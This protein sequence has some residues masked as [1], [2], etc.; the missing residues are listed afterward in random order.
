MADVAKSSEPHS[1]GLTSLLEI[2]REH[3]PDTD[4]TMLQRA[5][6]LA[7][8][9]HHGQTRKSGEPYINHPT[10]VAKI[11]AEIGMDRETIV[12]A[13]L[14]DVLEDTDIDQ[15]EI[16]ALFGEDVLQMIEG[17]TKLS[18]QISPDASARQK[19][20]A[21]SSRAAESLRKLL[22]AMAKDFRV[23]VIKLAD[24]LHNMRTISSLPPEKQTRIAN[25]T[26]DIYAPI[27]ARL[28]IFQVKWQ[29][30]D[31]AFKTLHPGEF[32]QIEE[33]VAK[34]RTEREQELKEAT[35]ALRKTL[36]ERGLGH[37]KVVGRP[38]HLFSIYN[39]HVK[40]GVPW[41]EIFDL[42]ALRVL[43]KERSECYTVLGIVYDLWEPI[44]G[45][46]TDHIATPKPNGYQS[47]HAKVVG[48]HGEPLEVQIRTRQMHEIAEFGVA[49][50]WAYKEGDEKNASSSG[51]KFADLR[52]QLFDWSNDNSTSSDFL[53]SVSTDLFSEQVF[54]FTPRGDIIDL[55]AGSTPVDF[56]FRVHSRVGETLV[57]AKING[58]IVPLG[59]SIRNGDVVEIL[60]RSNAQPSLDWLQHAKSPH[61]RSKLRH[62]FRV[63]DRAFIV[64]RGK[65]LV[66][67]ELRSV[68]LDAKQYS[69]DEILKQIVS[70]VRD[71]ETPADVLARVGEGLTSVQSIVSKIQ[72][73]VKTDDPTETVESKP[74][75]QSAQT[76]TN[77]DNVMFRRA[78]CCM[79]VPN[80]DVIGY[81][82]RG[83]GIM[84]HRR[85]CPNALRLA[86]TEGDRLSP[87]QWERSDATYPVDLKIVSINR[88]GLLMD[89]TTI[90]GE[91]KTN[92]TGA[93]ITTL[94]NNTAEINITI[95]VRDSA[96]LKELMT[97]ISNYSDVIS[98]LRVFG[99]GAKS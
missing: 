88:Q 14:H 5:Y 20:A 17:V 86:E 89:I 33:M 58:H 10:E 18:L 47:I 38:K 82:T 70:Q 7:E 44:P 45:L 23:M 36:K 60:T 73:L 53:R 4:D 66:E 6:R 77:I 57:G 84:I 71:C 91:S 37:C 8:A 81:V 50:H 63:R 25:E 95:E 94:P 83:R 79:P 90:F 31:L 65:E 1:A 16:E 13:L 21:E 93:K 69:S 67:R 80:E 43:T 74:K 32:Q 72:S 35:T 27:A 56:A 99:R 24:R 48:P 75:P 46:F 19:A 62:Y 54:A 76:A 40:Q 98:I 9:A 68:G 55:P 61:T 34:S 15:E 59:K 26:L 41:E 2:F 49:A 85:L 42:V 97:R 78:R 22:L 29:L 51:A 12:A 3:W 64:Q 96:H 92:V 52:R 11:V 28:G 87:V 39:K 30:E